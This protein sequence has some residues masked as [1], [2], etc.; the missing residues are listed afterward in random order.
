MCV[1][2]IDQPNL[3]IFVKFFPPFGSLYIIYVLPHSMFIP[4]KQIKRGILIL[5]LVGFTCA[6]LLADV[7]PDACLQHLLEDVGDVHDPARSVIRECFPDRVLRTLPRP[8]DE[9]IDSFPGL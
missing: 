6:P 7:N 1:C 9:R 8:K 2:A 5:H 4:C 3:F